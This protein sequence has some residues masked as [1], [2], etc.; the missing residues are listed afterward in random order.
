MQVYG[1][2]KVWKQMHREGVVVARCTV[3]RLMRHLGLR[4]AHRS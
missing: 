4:G 2:D 1:V 3:E